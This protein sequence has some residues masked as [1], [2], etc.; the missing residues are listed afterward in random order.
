MSKQLEVLSVSEERWRQA[1]GWESSVWRQANQKNSWLKILAKFARAAKTPNLLYSY[2]RFRDFYRGDD[3]NFWWAHAFDNYEGLPKTVER[4]LE[5][6]CGPFTNMRLISKRCNIR[7][8]CC[9]DPLI[10]VYT[11]FRLTWLSKQVAKNG[12]RAVPVKGEE[13]GFPDGY[14]DLVVCINVLDHVQDSR[15]CMEE[16]LRVTRPGGSI[17]FGQDL[18][19]DD[20]LADL[21][22]RTHIGHPI[23]LHH[24]TL[25]EILGAACE[26][27]LKKILPRHQGRDPR[28]HYG[29]YILIGRKK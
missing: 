12:A 18:C 19:D 6:G 9:S 27:V 20:D 2:L 5:I 17:V 13:L 24:T 22:Y 28:V 29:T 10:S 3:W 8:I 23:K 1:Q 11:Q 16:M 21:H 14:Y 26:P 4:A 25:D 15:R 7:N